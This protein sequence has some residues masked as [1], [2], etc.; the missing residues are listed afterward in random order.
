MFSC[1]MEN[2]VENNFQY[3]AV[4]EIVLLYSFSHVWFV[5]KIHGKYE[6]NSK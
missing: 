4:V 6:M 2:K 5:Q 1:T 3:L